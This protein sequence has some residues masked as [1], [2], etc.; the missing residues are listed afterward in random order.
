MTRNI[1][2]EALCADKGLRITEQRKTIARVLGDSEDHPDVE[3]LHAR[4]AEIDPN[5]SIATVY[6]TVRLFEEAGILE[7][8]E[9]GDGRSRFTASHSP[10]IAKPAAAPSRI[11]AGVRIAGL[12]LLLL[13]VLPL[14]LATMLL[15]GR[16]GWPR[17]FLAGTAWIC[18]ARVRV[19]GAAV[20]PHTLVVANHISWLDIL[21]LGGTVGT[22]FVS[23]D[24]LGHG[25]AHWLADQ[26][27]TVY[28][29]RENRRDAKAQALE[30]AAALEG[31]QPIG[32]FP[33][34]T[35]GP[36]THLL[37]FRSTLL[38]APAF[39]GK[40]VVV[41]PAALDYGADAAEISW[42]GE[43]AKDNVLRVLGRRGRTP[44]TVYLLDPLAPGDRKQLAQEA[45]AA[46]ARTLR[47]KSDPHSP[48][49]TGE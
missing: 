18:G 11:R 29:R 28:V 32:L 1:D 3:T 43:P 4:A 48:I 30:I 7:R 2:I 21:I 8:H 49:G 23:K 35:V 27:R 14:H 40:D 12:A 36:G 9:F 37:P 13:A 42:H 5:I 38:E 6:R 31:D 34:G 47:F 19:E 46:I 22:R 16:S 10:A 41:R 39:A 44:V 25:F 20:A 24:D 15:L 17:R 26:N 33:E 45:A